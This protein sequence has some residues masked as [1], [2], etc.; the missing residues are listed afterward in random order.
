MTW[1]AGGSSRVGRLER[2]KLRRYRDR[3]NEIR[4]SG[5]RRRSTT[6]FL[7]MRFNRAASCSGLAMSSWPRAAQDKEAGHNRLADVGRLG[8]E[9]NRFNAH[10]VSNESLDVR[11]VRAEDIARRVIVAASHALEQFGKGAHASISEESATVDGEYARAM[12]FGPAKNWLLR[13]RNRSDS[14]LRPRGPFRWFARAESFGRLDFQTAVRTA[15]RRGAGTRRFS[16][17][18][19]FDSILSGFAKVA[20][21]QIR[22]ASVAAPFTR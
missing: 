1:L 7:A 14:G 21:L 17:I 5:L 16:V 22:W 2:G 19:V 20:K 3:N 4:R 13:Y 10:Q 6:L 11:F 18:A 8:H 9:A 15:E 12:V